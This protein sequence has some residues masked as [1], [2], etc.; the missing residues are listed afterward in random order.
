MKILFT[1]NNF[2]AQF[3]HIYREL[4]GNSYLDIKFLAIGAEWSNDI[5]KEDLVRYN[6]GREQRRT[7]PSILKKI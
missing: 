3:R 7:M 2:P 1:H 6:L 4:K 5:N